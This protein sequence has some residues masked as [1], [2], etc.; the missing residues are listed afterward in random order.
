[1]LQLKEKIITYLQ[2]LAL[3]DNVAFRNVLVSMRPRSTRSDLPSSYDVKVHIH[4]Q[5]VRHMQE[6]KEAIRVS[7]FRSK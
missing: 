4:N 3:A 5:F 2:A 1:M 7:D 6:M